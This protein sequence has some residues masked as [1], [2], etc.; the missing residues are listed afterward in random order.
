MPLILFP[1]ILIY[2]ILVIWGTINTVSKQETSKRRVLFALLIPAVFLFGPFADEFIAKPYFYNLCNT[3]GG[4]QVYEE[5]H[6]SN[7]DEKWYED[8]FTSAQ[9]MEK[10]DINAQYK[11]ELGLIKEH[12]SVFNIRESDIKIYDKTNNKLI[13]LHK[14]YFYDYGVMRNWLA[15]AMPSRPEICHNISEPLF[16]EMIRKTFIKTTIE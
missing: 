5:V 15:T 2:V 14:R 11:W 1:I 4:L 3:K 13:S 9:V 6:L 8:V 12:K 7:I 10:F 16:K